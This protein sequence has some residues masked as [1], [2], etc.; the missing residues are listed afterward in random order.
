MKLRRFKDMNVKLLTAAAFSVAALTLQ[1]EPID[2]K[3]AT[4]LPR[5]VGQDFILRKLA[6]DWQK[7]SGGTVTLKIS[8]GG[9]KDGE[10]GI[11]KKLNSRN[12]QAGLLSAVGLCE[13]EKDVSALQY[14][15]LT[16]RTWEEVDFVRE[17]IRGKLE[18]K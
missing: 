10:A 7:T 16:F 11:V 5:G 8:P 9:Q 14:M 13:I 15:P 17:K 4:I 3:L 12:Y 6:E 2:V 18:E 1:A